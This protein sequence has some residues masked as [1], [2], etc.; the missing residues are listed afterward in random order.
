MAAFNWKSDVVHSC[1]FILMPIDFGSGV[2]RPFRTRR[3]LLAELYIHGFIGARRLIQAR[4]KA[5]SMNETK[6]SLYNIN[7]DLLSY[8]GL[9][10]RY[11]DPI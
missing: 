11:N 4:C 7:P 10:E 1:S 9:K 3:V 5:V 8:P 6:Q 2:K